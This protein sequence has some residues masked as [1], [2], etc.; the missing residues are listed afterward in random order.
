MY[1]TYNVGFK[2]TKNKEVSSGWY[3]Y[4][5]EYFFMELNAKYTIL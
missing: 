2:F 5:E 4:V 3:F 1:T